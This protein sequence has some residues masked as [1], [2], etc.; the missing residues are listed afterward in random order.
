MAGIRLNL[1][2]ATVVLVFE[3]WEEMGHRARK[4]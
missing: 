4:D 3:M 2:I 1:V